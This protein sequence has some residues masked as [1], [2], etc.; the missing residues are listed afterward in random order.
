[1]G[2]KRRVRSA[3]GAGS[4]GAA[5]NARVL[6]L[7]VDKLRISGQH[8]PELLQLGA[9]NAAVR[10]EPA[11]VAVASRIVLL[12]HRLGFQLRLKLRLRLRLGLLLRLWLRLCPLRGCGCGR[13]RC[14]LRRGRDSLLERLGDGLHPA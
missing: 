6:V 10:L 12:L 13:G 14:S 3:V 9:V 8:E 1:M 7:V 2:S 11:L 5:A 4:G